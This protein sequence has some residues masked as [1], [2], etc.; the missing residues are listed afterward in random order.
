MVDA[1]YNYDRTRQKTLDKYQP[2]PFSVLNW[3]C[4]YHN[5][6]EWKVKMKEPVLRLNGVI[7]P[8]LDVNRTPYS[9]A[10]WYKTYGQSDER[11][12][13]RTFFGGRPKDSNR[14]AI[15]TPTKKYRVFISMCPSF[16]RM[17]KV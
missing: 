14:V 15:A 12:V 5:E 17:D 7:Y 13:V 10:K 1:L 11:C 3:D 2:N 6:T 8:S 4:G 16:S 9:S